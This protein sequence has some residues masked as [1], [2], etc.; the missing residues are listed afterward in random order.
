MSD[1][2]LQGMALASAERLS[3]ARATADLIT[4]ERRAAEHKAPPPLRLSATGFD[5]IAELKKRS[6]AAGQLA[7]TAVSPAAQA[8]KY[9]AAGAAAISV[10]T[11]PQRFSGSLEDLQ[12]VVAGTESIPVMRKDFLVDPYQIVEARAAGAGGVLLIAAILEPSLLRDMLQTAFE[13]GM[14]VLVEAFDEADLLRCVPVMADRLPAINNDGSCRMLLGVNCR[15]LRTLAVEFTRFMALAGQLPDTIPWVAESGVDT[16]YK[17]GQV[18]SAGYRLALVG[19]A[20][21]RSD[22]PQHA[23]QALLQAGR[24]ARAC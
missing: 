1:D 4:L 6:P 20:L 24:D 2:F 17:A 19:T 8:G 12:Q 7:T 16:P 3:E 15:N 23:A 5:L 21:M 9:V 22:G 14:F 18:A 13:L 10:L 11:E